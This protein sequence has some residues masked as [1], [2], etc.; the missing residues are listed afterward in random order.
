MEYLFVP[1]YTPASPFPPPPSA[2]ASI[3]I[4][5][6]ARR[7]C[8]IVRISE[9]RDLCFGPLSPEKT[10]ICRLGVRQTG[11]VRGDGWVRHGKSCK[12]SE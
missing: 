5:N 12:R 10:V 6:P 1:D 2:P 7:L 11:I 8:G 3:H 4:N 9:E